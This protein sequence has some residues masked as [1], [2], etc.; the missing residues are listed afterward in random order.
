[1]CEIGEVSRSGYY[2]WLRNFDKP[3]KDT[4]DYEL[5]R[6]IFEK[7]KR[8]LGW[9]SVQ[10]RLINERKIIMNHKKI[11][12]IMRKYHLF[13]KIRSR[14]PYKNIAKKT[15]EHQTC[16][17]KL[18]RQFEQSVPLKVFCTDI[19]YLFFSHHLAY[20]SVIK[21]IC[22]G[23]IVAWKSS[24]HIDMD[25]VLKT[26]EVM[27][28]NVDLPISSFDN[29]MIH[30]DQGFHYT[31][32]QYIKVVKDLNMVQ[33]MSRKGN[34]IDNAP[35]K[36]FFGHFKDDVDYKECRTYEELEVL[37]R[38]YIEYYNNERYQWD[39][40]KMTPVQYRNHLLMKN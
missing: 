13:V 23:E 12:R 2:K 22:S 26:V 8:K 30:S 19:T 35:M 14:N 37:I 7:G 1:M 16:E 4:K 11:Q 27:K 15:Q 31:N 34:C 10:M 17:N 33:S 24:P 39:L 38:D 18:N 28:N 6:E 5:I 25:L 32:P 9:R 40:K 21:D 3:D 36:S 20:L 29:I